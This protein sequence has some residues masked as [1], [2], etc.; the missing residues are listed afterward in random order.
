MASFYLI[1]NAHIDPVWQ[2]CMPEGMSLVRSTFRSALDR[3]KEYPDYKFTSACAFYYKWVK[4]I[5]PDMFEEIKERI[6]EGRWGIAG[7]MWVQPDCNI[8]SGE[9]FCRH[10]L[11]SQNFFKEN[12]GKTYIGTD[13]GFNVLARPMLYGSY[14]EIV[15]PGHEGEEKIA[16]TVTGNICESGDILAKDRELPVPN[17][18]DPVAIMTA[19]AYG[20]MMSSTYNCRLR[21]AEVLITSDGQY[22]LIRRRETLEDLLSTM[23]L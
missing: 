22:E 14:H 21:P 16:A 12:F 19:G 5:D 9:S 15:F 6:S 13:I 18:G 23:I 8:P 10:L 7:G 17:T 2:W 3:M 1:G 4:E 20:Y 11:Y